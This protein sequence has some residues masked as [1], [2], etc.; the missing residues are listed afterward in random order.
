MQDGR[1]K[2]TQRKQQQGS[3][4][5]QLIARCALTMLA[6][7]GTLIFQTSPAEAYP[8]SIATTSW[9]VSGLMTGTESDKISSEIFAMERIG[10]VLYVGGRFT[11]VTN[12]ATSI[13]QPGLAAFHAE[14][15][16]WI[17]SFTPTL[18][19][20]VYTLRASPDGTR[21]FVGGDFT[22]VDGTWSSA[23]TALDPTTGLEDSSW[24]GRVGGYQVVRDLQI[25]DNHLYVGGGFTSV[26]DNQLHRGANRLARFDLATGKLDPTWF[27]Q[28]N[29]GTVRGIAISP[30]MGR[31]YVAGSLKS[32][33]AYEVTNGFASIDIATAEHTENVANL[34]I[35]AMGT[36]MHFSIDVLVANGLVWVAG[37]QHSLQVLDEATL[38]LDT[39]YLS[40]HRGDFQDLLLVGDTVYAGCHCPPYTDIARSNGILWW[41]QKPDGVVNAPILDANA[42]S[43]LSAFDANTGLRDT[44]FVPNITSR[45]YGVWALAESGDGCLW[46][47]GALTKTGTTPQFAMTRLCEGGDDE[48]PSVPG[49]ATATVDANNNATLTWRA[50]TD[51]VGVSGYRIYDESTNAVLLTTT[52]N[53]GVLN[54]LGVGTTQIYV[55]AFDDGGNESWRS[56][57]TAV[58][59]AGNQG[60]TTAPSQTGTPWFKDNASGNLTVGWKPST[61]NVAVVGYRVYN[62]VTGQLLDETNEN[63]S[64][65]T[66]LD[67]GE[68]QLS[69]IAFDAAGNE[70]SVSPTTTLI[71]KNDPVV[72]P[73]TERPSKPGAPIFTNNQ[74][75]SLTVTWAPATDNVGVVR[76]EL[77]NKSTHVLLA[78]VSGTEVTLTNLAAGDLGVYLR[79]FDAAGNQSWRSPYGSVRVN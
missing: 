5:L 66:N 17:P 3:R 2:M 16:E 63:R 34:G 68:L 75:G 70:S 25:Y 31:I 27:P 30:D 8:S 32:V 7:L 51:N 55:R 74:G 19:G 33:G 42:N 40:R 60:D 79:A 59:I 14:T 43:W 76:Y 37:S 57:S 10:D 78:E 56:G 69:V 13:S 26:R 64:Y 45:G 11:H 48:R 77:R 15:G 21:L 53:T 61:D 49:R 65:L 71:V 54:G 72:V 18:N 47:G 38:E 50:A 1:H 35:N 52:T 36:T 58:V 12:G 9:G 23:L 39:F 73:D 20:A 41:G 62:T 28:I 24:E 22:A 44:S 6:V 46:I 4:T 67:A 29:G